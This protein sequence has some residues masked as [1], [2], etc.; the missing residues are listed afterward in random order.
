MSAPAAGRRVLG[1]LIFA[2]VMAALGAVC[3]LPASAAPPALWDPSAPETAAV[4]VRLSGSGGRVWRI[5]P[6]QD[7]LPPALPVLRLPL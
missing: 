3:A 2:L 4:T 6:L 1:P 7:A 5:D